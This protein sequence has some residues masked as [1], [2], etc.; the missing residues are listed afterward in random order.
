MR[1]GSQL[2]RELRGLRGWRAPRT[3][4]PA[5]L[6]R[7]QLGD[8]YLSCDSPV[9]RV[10]VAYNQGGI[11][12][13]TRAPAD[14]DFERAHAA[15]RGRPARRPPQPPTALLRRI[16]R[17]LSE[18]SGELRFDLRG[19]SPFQRAVLYKAAEIPRGEVRPY[20]WIAQEIGH[21]GAVRAVGSALARNPVPLLIPCHRVVRSD[22]HI[23]D[24]GLGGA[25][26]KRAILAA[27]G[28]QPRRLETL[29]RAG[30]RYL[31]SDSTHIYCFPSCRQAL[32]ISEPHRVAFRSQAQAAAAGYRPCRL[33]R[34]SPARAS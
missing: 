9:G 12:R 26:T 24:Y 28:V 13:V 21:A 6:D 33:C 17:R 10:F 5:V 20:S 4:L 30:V 2:V 14:E 8:A 1:Q 29:A 22:G 32:R 16:R 11:S 15:R 3:L 19:L 34:P 27:E 7:L 23:G 18:G 25:P 31:G